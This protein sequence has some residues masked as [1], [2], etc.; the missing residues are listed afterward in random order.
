MTTLSQC[1]DST[2][3]QT[4]KFDALDRTNST[5]GGTCVV[6][7]AAGYKLASGDSLRALTC[8]S[9]NESV[10]CLT[11]SWP[12]C[13]VTRCLTST[14]P[15]PIG[16]SEDCE[17]IKYGAFCQVAFQR[18]SF[19]RTRCRAAKS[20]FPIGRWRGRTAQCGWQSQS[21][22]HKPTSDSSMLAPDCTDLTSG[23][24]CNVMCAAGYTDSA[25]TL[26]CNLD[27]VNG[28]VS[29]IGSLP[30]CSAAL[31]AGDLLPSGMSHDCDR[32]AFLD[33]CYANCAHRRHIFHLSSNG[34]LVSDTTPFL[35]RL[36]GVVL[37][38]QCAPGRRHRSGLGLLLFDLG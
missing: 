21:R 15:V 33:S 9:E 30:N 10:A 6:R 34:F 19:T 4:E 28:S 26:T 20:Y 23:D 17:S 18:I 29:L 13:K 7:C 38:E 36:K 25:S 1:S 37:P 8:V 27:V 12:A 32:I 16:V 5:V 11:G 3:T 35:S 14:N 31:C 2:I 22:L 24:H